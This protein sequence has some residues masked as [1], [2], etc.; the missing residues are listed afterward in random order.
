M[1]FSFKFEGDDI[2]EE[3][4]EE[5]LAEDFA[6]IYVRATEVLPPK[7]HT[8][9]DLVSWISLVLSCFLFHQSDISDLCLRHFFIHLNSKTFS[10]VLCLHGCCKAIFVIIIS[11]IGYSYHSLH[12]GSHQLAFL[13]FILQFA[14]PDRA[15]LAAIGNPFPN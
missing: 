13:C 1:V 8:L 5:M 15:E 12:I 10:H 14:D 6:K 9:R 2:S 7:C 4:G 3:S 11:D